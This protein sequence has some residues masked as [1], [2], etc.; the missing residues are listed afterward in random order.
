MAGCTQGILG[1][2]KLGSLKNVWSRASRMPTDCL[3]VGFFYM[4]KIGAS[5]T[6]L[7]Q[8]SLILMDR[9]NVTKCNEMNVSPLKHEI[10]CFHLDRFSVSGS[11]LP[12]AHADS[13]IPTKM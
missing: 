5:A 7:L 6:L 1:I 4:R 9:M 10:K 11:L 8:L 12:S 2:E 13:F 3:P